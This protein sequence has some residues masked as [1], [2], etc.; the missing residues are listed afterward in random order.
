M[1]ASSQTANRIHNFSAGPCTLPVEALQEAREHLVDYHGEGM[2]LIEMSHRSKT[3]D[4]VHEGA[5]ALVRELLDLP[6]THKVLF[7]GGGATMQFAMTA[8]NCLRGGSADYTCSGSWSK[9]AIADAKKY[10]RVNV[11]W[12]GS[13]EK[14]T[15]LP[16]PASVKTSDGAAYLHLTSNETIEGVQWQS[17]PD[18]EAPIVADMSSD[19]MSRPIPAEKF[20]VIYAGAQKNIG[21]AGVTL[22]IVR[23]D[24]LEQ[25]P[26]D[27][28]LYFNY[29]NH[30]EKNSLLNT[31]P[32]FQVWMVKLV[33]EWVKRNGGLAWAREMARTKSGMVYDAIARQGG[34]Y[35]CPVDPAHRSSM[36][37][38]FRL[39]SE[40][41]E[42][43]FIERAE[44]EGLSGLKG[45]RS[46]GGCRASL[47]NAMPLEGVEALTGFMADFAAR[48]G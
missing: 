33:L 7:L 48:H 41:L 28:P 4:A 45:H 17:F 25:C 30:A 32:V 15:T 12:D 35:R 1:T 2:G 13:E 40:A 46:V 18:V 10:G 29:R 14:F 38:V 26:D 42:K 23:D 9:K 31:P 3:Y 11:V 21:P 24:V 16:D 6:Q 36:N 39:P 47:Y 20:G 22:V 8:A 19:I 34:F 27:L 44:A 37:V 43:D 5:I